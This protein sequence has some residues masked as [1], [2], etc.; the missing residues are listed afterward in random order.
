[1]RTVSNRRATEPTSSPWVAA[2]TKRLVVTDTVTPSDQLP[3]ET[4]S[5]STLLADAVGRLHRAE[6]LDELG[7]YR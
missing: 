3:I 7:A 6:P 5:V 1:M 2:T 4:F